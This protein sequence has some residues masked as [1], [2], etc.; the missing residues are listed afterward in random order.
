MNATSTI[1]RVARLF[2]PRKPALIAPGGA[3][4]LV[5]QEHRERC[6]HHQ[7]GPAL[8]VVVSGQLL[9]EL[10]LGLLRLAVC[11]SYLASLLAQTNCIVDW[12]AIRCAAGWNSEFLHATNTLVG[13]ELTMSC[14]F[15][16]FSVQSSR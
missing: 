11:L 2:D 10:E 4:D 14:V 8:A 6:G 12:F 13:S 3:G 5:Q 16:A 7:D 15:G 9:R 1:R